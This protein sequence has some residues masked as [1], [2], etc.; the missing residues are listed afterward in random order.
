[1]ED[2]ISQALALAKGIW[3][4]RFWAVS[5]AWVILIGGSAAVYAIPDQYNASARVFVDTESILKPLLAGMTSVPNVEQ[6][7]SIMSRTLITRPN[8]EKVVRMVDLDLKSKTPKEHE[9]LID[10][11]MKN[12]KI[13]GMAQNDIY[14][15]SY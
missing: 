14:T 8:V 7:V 11:L 1:M 12:I 13:A 9:A 6:Q 4:Y 15:I 2:L 5:T 10:D 3:K